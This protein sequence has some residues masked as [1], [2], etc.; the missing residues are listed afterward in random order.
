MAKSQSVRS[1][2][3]QR[4]ESTEEITLDREH[5]F[6]MLSN[7]RR[8]YVL[9]YLKQRPDEEPVPLRD[10]VDQVA[11]WENDTTVRELDSGDRKCV[12]TALKQTHLP[13]LDAFGV[14]EYDP[15]RSE[16]ELDDAME[17]VQVYLE[18]VPSD[19][20]SW[21]QFYLG[22]TLIYAGL[23]G[24]I[25]VGA[26]LLGAIDWVVLATLFVFLYLVSSLVHLRRSKANKIG[27]EGKLEETV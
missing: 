1:T 8:R 21:S 12:Y 25:L 15:R 11:A 27:H 14:I 10:I 6:E 17:D 24:A 9:H 26:P 23:V 22:V 20:I 19:D 2:E 3:S 16:V 13:R 5:I 4:G 7:R 18:Y